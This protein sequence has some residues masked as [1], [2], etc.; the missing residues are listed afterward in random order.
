MN[1]SRNILFFHAGIAVLAA[2]FAFFSAPEA[3]D[4]AIIVNWSY[5][6]QPI[7]IRV[8]TDRPIDAPD[9]Q[10]AIAALK[11]EARLLAESGARGVVVTRPSCGNTHTF[12]I[13][14]TTIPGGAGGGGGA[15]A[16]GGRRAYSPPP[17]PP[18]CTQYRAGAWGA[19]RG[20]D[21]ET[22]L[23]GTQT[24]SVTAYQGGCPAGSRPAESRSCDMPF[25]FTL[26]RGASSG[27]TLSASSDHTIEVVFVGTS[28][29]PRS[30]SK[31]IIGLNPAFAKHP[32]IT[33]AEFE[34][35]SVDPAIPDETEFFLEPETLTPDKF[36][37]GT[38]FWVKIP[39]INPGEYPIRI[40]VTAG[41]VAKEANVTLRVRTADP[42]FNEI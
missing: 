36:G 27:G 35:T 6:G 28:A 7:A 9:V 11:H 42:T 23:G 38:K 10:R 29:A 19:C 2:S 40:R 30:S 33:P 18:Q 16:A 32:D 1:L 26:L 5:R 17:P 21:P 34:V 25:D 4:A 8:N 24:R 14:G 37:E 13:G 22:G 3:A 31:T 41:G 15:P 39:R 20:Y 12:N